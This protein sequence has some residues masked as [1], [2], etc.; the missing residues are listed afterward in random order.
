MTRNQRMARLK[1]SL[2]AAD[3]QLRTY[4]LIEETTKAKLEPKSTQ[5]LAFDL[6]HM[7]DCR[8][9]TAQR[10]MNDISHFMC[11]TASNSA[12]EADLKMVLREQAA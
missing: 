11:L 6:S 4:W 9:Q 12:F 7:I 1:K 8:M 5:D 10:L 2:N 3:M